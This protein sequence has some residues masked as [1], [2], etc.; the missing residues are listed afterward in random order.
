VKNTKIKNIIAVGMFLLIALILGQSFY[1]YNRINL[2]AEEKMVHVQKSEELNKT[3][4]SIRKDEKD[5]LLRERTNP[6]YFETGES[7]YLK[8]IMKKMLKLMTYWSI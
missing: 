1:A 4:L 8:S 7:K 6:D 5:F 3:M 2:L